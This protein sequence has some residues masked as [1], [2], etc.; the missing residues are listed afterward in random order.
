M[1]SSILFLFILQQTISTDVSDY[2]S[3]FGYLEEDDQSLKKLN[4]SDALLIFQEHN[5]LPVTGTANNETLELMKKSRCGNKDTL[6][7]FRIS[8]SK[9]DKLN[10]AWHYRKAS[11]EMMNLAKIAFK[12]WSDHSGLTFRHDFRNPDILISNQRLQHNFCAKNKPCS[13]SFDGR[14]VVLGHAYFPSRENITEI[15]IDLDEDWY[16]GLD[17]APVG[18]T[19]LISVL[20]HEIG[21]SLGLQHSDNPNA[22]MY[23]WYNNDHQTDLNQDDKFAIQYLYGPPSEPTVKPVTLKPTTRKTVT[24]KSVIQ[25]ELNSPELCNIDNIK[26]FLIINQRM[27][28]VHDKWIWTKNNGEDRY[29]KP[30]HISSLLTNLPQDF[31]KI[32]GVYQR[33]SGQIVLFIDDK[34]YMYEFPS[35]QL[36]NGYPAPNYY[37]GIPQDGIIHGVV[38]TYSGRTFIFYNDM[39]FIELDECK[40][41]TKDRGLISKVFPGVPSKMD[42]VF[43]FTNGLLYFF[44]DET[45][46]EFNEFTNNLVRAGRN[47]LNLFGIQCPNKSI[48]ERLK[49]LLEKLTPRLKELDS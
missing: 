43:R 18:R 27:Y 14:G 5:N 6:G 24:Q 47:D 39:Y 26:T 10:L 23:A 2:L 32:N 48:L 38:N 17:S 46:Y 13:Y 31:K 12:V 25:T 3:R 7:E 42:S 21:H 15:H 1:R 22:T 40:F 34:T 41:H 29:E 45:Y 11:P 8:G 16:L 30:M 20:I 44:K 35:L 9:W 19:S 4:V 36:V 33:P 28:I 49:E 37:L